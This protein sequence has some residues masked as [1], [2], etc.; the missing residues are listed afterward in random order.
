MKAMS[1][2]PARIAAIIGSRS[3]TAQ[4]SLA[5][6]VADWRASGVRVV[7]LLGE[8]HGLPDRTCGA[9]FLRDITS[10]R[11]FSIYS[12]AQPS[13]TACHL[14]AAGVASACASL[15]D[16]I[17]TSDLVALNKFG[18]LE[19][20]HEGLAAAF[21]AAIAA[22]KPLLTTVSDSHLGAWR[23]FA[24]G[25]ILLPADEAALRNW[26][27]AVQGAGSEQMA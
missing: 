23:Q 24:P 16:Q 8:V 5:A 4:A 22:G 27:C 7:G 10:S 20:A 6:I 9:G 18:K 14:D 21:D 26:W 25:A 3:A 13:S 12:E 11:P 1:S 17:P 2:V 19:A 15:L